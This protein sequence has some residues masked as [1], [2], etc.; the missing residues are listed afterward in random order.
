MLRWVKAY[1]TDATLVYESKKEVTNTLI[2]DKLHKYYTGLKQTAQVLRCSKTKHTDTTLIQERHHKYYNNPRYNAQ[3]QHWS[4]SD[5]T[6]TK[7]SYTDRTKRNL[8]RKILHSEYTDLSQI[9]QI[10]HWPR[11]IVNVQSYCKF[12]CTDTS[13]IQGGEYWVTEEM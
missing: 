2:Q 10:L 4:W 12:E 6:G 11:H 13:L 3:I 1:R 9:T 7:F 8:T 5:L